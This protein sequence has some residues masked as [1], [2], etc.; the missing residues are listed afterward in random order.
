MRE[1]KLPREKLQDPV[2]VK[3]HPFHR[4]RDGCRTPMQ[5]D[6]SPQA[7]FSRSEPWLPIGPEAAEHNVAA[8]DADPHSQLN[9]MKELIWRRKGLP[10]LLNGDYRS[11]TEGVPED[12]FCYMRWVEEQ[13]LAVFLNFSPHEQEIDLQTA[14][15]AVNLLISTNPEREPGGAVFPL[16][17]APEEGCLMELV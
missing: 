5:W 2:G 7:G 9:F 13:E 1:A 17:L 15:N 11:I 6:D 16:I 12:C 4:G 8:Q 3:W 14:N 10:A